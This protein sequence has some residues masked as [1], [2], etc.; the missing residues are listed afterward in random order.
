MHVEPEAPK[1]LEVVVNYPEQGEALL[2]KKVIDE[3]IQRRILFKTV[4][5]VE[6]K[7]CKLIIDS[8]STDNLVSTE[9]VEKRNLKRTVH[10]KPY[11][12]AWLQKGQQVLVNEQ[13]GKLSVQGLG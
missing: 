11:I 3:S 5:K 13:C 12:V 8:G 1:E 9:M 7:C 4:C 10:P 6:G 2:L